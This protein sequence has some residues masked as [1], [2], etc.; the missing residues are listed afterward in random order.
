MESKWHEDNVMPKK[1]KEQTHSGGMA[2]FRDLT[3][4]R[5]ATEKE[6]RCGKTVHKF[7]VSSCAMCK[8]CRTTAE[9][10]WRAVSQKTRTLR[11]CTGGA[12]G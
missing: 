1:L 2:T 8:V 4:I 5:G 7:T 9:W 10:P 11:E 6:K 12:C 3:L